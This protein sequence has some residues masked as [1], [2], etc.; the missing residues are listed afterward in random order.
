MANADCDTADRPAAENKRSWC[1]KAESINFFAAVLFYAVT[2]AALVLFAFTVAL[3]EL[4]P[5]NILTMAVIAGGIGGGLTLALIG[6]EKLGLRFPGH[7]SNTKVFE[8]GFVGEIFVGI[9]AAAVMFGIGGGVADLK[10][11]EYVEG[12]SDL[13]SLWFRNF[14]LAHL[15]GF[16]GISLIKKLAS[17]MLDTAAVADLKQEAK[18]TEGDTAYLLGLQAMESKQLEAAE[19]YMRKALE[20]EGTKSIRAY[21]GLAQV[22]KRRGRIGEA[23]SLLNEALERQD[24]EPMKSRVAKAYFNRACYL[25][26]GAQGATLTDGE[27]SKV[28]ESLDRAFKHDKALARDVK[29]DP[30]FEKAL[31]SARFSQHLEQAL[32]AA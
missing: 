13:Y 12:K 11:F 9:M 24:S 2:V 1:P 25:S 32:H 26:V 29:S 23:L 4:S 14:A 15:S 16:L 22:M 28:I 3:I 10:P 21:I 31:Q 7:E 18:K 6:G 30:D 27:V 8:P 17:G 19:N 20:V 5:Q